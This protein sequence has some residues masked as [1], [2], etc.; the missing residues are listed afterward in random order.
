MACCIV[1]LQRLSHAFRRLLHADRLRLA[2]M[3]GLA[4]DVYIDSGF[5]RYG[6]ERLLAH[7]DAAAAVNGREP[8]TVLTAQAFEESRPLAARYFAHAHEG[9]S[10]KQR[11]SSR[12]KARPL[13]GRLNQIET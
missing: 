2:D 8:S 13:Q 10:G 6:F 1:N 12:L 3:D 5:C 7:L 11:A 9:I 4:P